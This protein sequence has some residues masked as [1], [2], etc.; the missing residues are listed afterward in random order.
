MPAARR[1][2]W[3]IHLSTAVV[4]VLVSGTVLGINMRAPRLLSAE[5]NDLRSSYTF[6][7][8]W[9]AVNYRIG[10]WPFAEDV[11]TNFYCRESDNR[12]AKEFAQAHL[13]E[14]LNKRIPTKFDLKNFTIATVIVL[15][16]TAAC[17]FIIRRRESR[18]H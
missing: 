9:I 1:H 11:Q 16:I 13:D 5:V 3:Q 8:R 4:V 18:F 10:G 6:S 14:M 15:S 2:L 17:E 7:G 12:S